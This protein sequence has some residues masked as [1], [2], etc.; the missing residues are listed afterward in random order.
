MTASTPAP[1][2]VA[3]WLAPIAILGAVGLWQAF[4]R[5]ASGSADT[6]PAA[7]ATPSMTLSLL[8]EYQPAAI[9]PPVGN[10]A[11]DRTLFN[12]TRRPAPEKP[13]TPEAA[14][15]RMQKG[16]FALSG[17]LII[18]GTVMAFLREAKGG[19]SRKVKQGEAIEGMTV[20]EIKPDR[21]RLTLGDESEDLV[22]KVAAGPKTTIQPVVANSGPIT[23]TAQGMQ[24]PPGTP[25]AAPNPASA[26]DVS[27]L[28]AE[29][30]R[31][32]RALEQAGGNPGAAGAT[33]AAAADGMPQ[34]GPSAPIQAPTMPAVPKGDMGTNDPR[35]QQ[36][37]QR[38]QQPRR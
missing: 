30:R 1:R 9:V 32:A 24:P 14:K 27:E 16:Q 22:L 19:K 7:A 35:W 3:V 28:L 10:D 37:Y 13:A 11:V 2:R 20:A 6:A 18:D 26:R 12:P 36:L 8:P 34:P 33:G 29:R 4:P 15:P 21:V 23:A 17:T 5:V 25:G 38:Y 31:Q